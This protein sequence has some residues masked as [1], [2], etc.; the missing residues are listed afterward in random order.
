MGERATC[1]ADLLQRLVEHVAQVGRQLVALPL[2][3][4]PHV[5]VQRGP[6]AAALHGALV[7]RHEQRE[8]RLQ[9]HQ[10]LHRRLHHYTQGSRSQRESNLSGHGTLREEEG[11]GRASDLQDDWPLHVCP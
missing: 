6:V 5:G 7:G 9:L 4:C 8:G 11:G 3:Q 1:L 10:T 2:V